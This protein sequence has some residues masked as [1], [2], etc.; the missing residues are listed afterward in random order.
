V[1]K[2]IM[3]AQSHIR[4]LSSSCEERQLRYPVFSS[5]WFVPENKQRVTLTERTTLKLNVKILN[6]T[7]TV[8]FSVTPIVI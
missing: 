1:P 4:R 7:I 6:I 2:L 5:R 3:I 8:T